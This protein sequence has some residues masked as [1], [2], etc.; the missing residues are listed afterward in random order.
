MADVVQ[1]IT[2]PERQEEYRAKLGEDLALEQF[3]KFHLPL[4]QRK[5]DSERKVETWIEQRED[6]FTVLNYLDRWKV[7]FAAFR[8]QG[9]A[10]D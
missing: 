1:N 10:R 7:Q 9:P 2:R 4:F 3:L 8:L 6:I 5:T